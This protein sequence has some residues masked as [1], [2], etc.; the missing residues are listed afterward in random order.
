MP[1]LGVVAQ[2]VVVW[3]LV[4]AVDG[5]LEAFPAA[6]RGE[7]LVAHLE[8]A[9][10]VVVE[11]ERVGTA[12]RADRGSCRCHQLAIPFHQRCAGQRTP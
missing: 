1:D 9:D 4:G 5:L 11:V 3:V 6:F 12:Y 10:R 8:G 2:P 7:R